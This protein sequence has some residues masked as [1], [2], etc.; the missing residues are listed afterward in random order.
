MGGVVQLV[1]PAANPE[2][3]P[4]LLQVTE[5][6][7]KVSAAVPRKTTLEADVETFVP[8]G[9][10]IAILGAVVSFPFAGGAA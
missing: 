8:A 4:E 7:P 9:D 2:P 3:P 5:A 6:T 10:R 1:V